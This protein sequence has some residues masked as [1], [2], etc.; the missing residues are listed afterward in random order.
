MWLRWKRELWLTL[1]H[2]SMC[3]VGW[4]PQYMAISF[5]RRSPVHK[6]H[7]PESCIVRVYAFF[8]LP[9]SPQYLNILKTIP[10][11][12]QLRTHNHHHLPQRSSPVLQEQEKTTRSGSDSR[13][14]QDLRSWKRL[15]RSWW[16]TSFMGRTRRQTSQFCLHLLS[17]VKAILFIVWYWWTSWCKLSV[18]I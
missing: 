16:W 18:F 7:D 5:Q 12:S 9:T 11:L 10:V 17:V 2:P 14:H 1:A 15:Q 3:H 4:Y 13:F 6:Y 8:P